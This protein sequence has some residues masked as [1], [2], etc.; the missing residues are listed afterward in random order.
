MKPVDKISVS[1]IQHRLES[2]VAEMGETLLRTA[3]SQTMNSSSNIS[4]AI[5][6]NQARLV[7]QAGSTPLHIGALSFAVTAI[8][9]FFGQRI[10]PGDVYLLN[11][12]YHGGNHL[13]DLIVFVPVFAGGISGPVFWM[14]SRAHLSYFGSETHASHKTSVA[15]IYQQ[16][17]RVTPLKIYDRG[18]VR[19][20]VVHML[21]TNVCNIADFQGDLGAMVAA[22]RA[23][24][25]RLQRLIDKYSVAVVQQVISEI[26]DASERL[27]RACI[28]QW[29]DGVY[30]GESVLNGDDD[31][32]ENIRIRAIV[33]KM[34]DSLH[35]DLTECDPQ[36]TGV[37]NSSYANTVSAIHRAFAFLIDTS[38]LKNEGVFRPIAL[39]TKPKTIAHP[40]EPAPVSLT[41]NQ[42]SEKI[43]E[44]VIKAISA[45][46]PESV[47]H[48]KAAV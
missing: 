36:V 29:V 22:A 12:P 31:G 11:D 44:T 47:E 26:W 45:A 10:H 48:L 42:P 38:A 15:E 5:F 27:S 24:E 17:M 20:D 16:G 1:V 41:S 7:A 40:L 37:M 2:I 39:T 30:T 32:I 8:E 14:L 3:Y 46:Y 19:D 34:G 13:Q 43:F 28:S 9:G 6:D 35:V 21:S 33:T 25:G 4:T 23:G 18:E